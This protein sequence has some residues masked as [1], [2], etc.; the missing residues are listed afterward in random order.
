ME[1]LRRVICR[2]NRQLAISPVADHA[3]A[4]K[5]DGAMPR[6]SGAEVTRASYPGKPKPRLKLPTGR[7]LILTRKTPRHNFIN[8]A[9]PVIVEPIQ[10]ARR[11]QFLSTQPRTRLLRVAASSNP[12]INRTPRDE[13]EQRP[14]CQTLGTPIE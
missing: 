1:L 11:L 3:A 7:M 12:S 9:T 5:S 10:T 14:L 6:Q 2:N 8:G 4:I 13:A